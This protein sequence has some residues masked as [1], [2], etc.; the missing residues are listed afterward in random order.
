MV[1]SKQRRILQAGRCPWSVTRPGEAF[2]PR[3]R[4]LKVGKIMAQNL[5]T[6]GVQVPL[7]LRTLG[8][9][10][11]YFAAAAGVSG[12]LGCRRGIVPSWALKNNAV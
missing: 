4:P 2:L 10:G 8:P 9:V 11:I 6:F 3:P 1:R 7:K 5:Y 12:L